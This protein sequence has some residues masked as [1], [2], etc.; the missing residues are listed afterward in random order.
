MT[1]AHWMAIA[2]VLI[3]ILIT[4]LDWV[5]CIATKRTYGQGYEDDEQLRFLQEV[6]AEKIKEQ[7]E[8]EVVA[9]VSPSEKDETDGR[10]EKRSLS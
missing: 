6:R 8:R 9:S 7:N 4:L 5:L 3:G 2:V 1:I 10:G